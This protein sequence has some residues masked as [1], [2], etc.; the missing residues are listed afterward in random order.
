[1]RRFVKFGGDP[2]TLPPATPTT[3]ATKTEQAYRAI[4]EMSRRAADSGEATQAY[5]LRQALEFING[6]TST[7]VDKLTAR[8][9]ALD[10][11]STQ[12][13]RAM[14]RPPP[15]VGPT[16]SAALSVT[17]RPPARVPPTTMPH[18]RRLDIH[19]PPHSIARSVSPAFSEPAGGLVHATD[20]SGPPPASGFPG[21]P[22]PKPPA[23]KPA[24]S[25][26]G[27]STRLPPS[28]APRPRNRLPPRPQSRLL[29]PGHPRSGCN[30]PTPRRPR[31]LRLR[32]A[33][34]RAPGRR[35]PPPPIRGAFGRRR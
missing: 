19:F 3:G 17:V 31:P 16:T 27:G 22:S 15:R 29:L 24:T 8:Y 2:K 30:R 9:G 20:I 34:G 26:A 7:E 28:P 14:Q 4:E 21:L 6:F 5:E 32:D 1:M 23:R 25:G 33:P 18:P 11:L 12:D 13:I 10:A 35:P